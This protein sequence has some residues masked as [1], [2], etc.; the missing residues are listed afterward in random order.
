MCFHVLLLAR[1]YVNYFFFSCNFLWETNFVSCLS[2]KH[3]SIFCS[4]FLFLNSQPFPPTLL[5]SR[6]LT[7][8]FSVVSLWVSYIYVSLAWYPLDFLPNKNR[9]CCSLHILPVSQPVTAVLFA[10]QQQLHKLWKLTM[11]H[12]FWEGRDR[13]HTGGWLPSFCLGAWASFSVPFP[14]DR[15]HRS[16]VLLSCQKFKSLLSWSSPQK[17]ISTAVG[18]GLKVCGWHS[19]LFI[20]PARPA[21]C[22]VSAQILWVGDGPEHSHL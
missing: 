16:L 7:E 1:P 18:R 4:E 5:L 9:L 17:C 8:Q 21:E 2:S 3:R 22:P 19:S 6:L 14:P 13:A 12:L 15:S 11:E 10:S 20:Q